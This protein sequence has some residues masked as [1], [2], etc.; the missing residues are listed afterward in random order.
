MAVNLLL[1]FIFSGI[2]GAGG[3]YKKALSKTGVLGALVVGTMIF[4]LGGWI[5]GVVLIAFFI[6][7]SGLSFFKAKSKSA[8]A[9]KFD[10]GHRR[11]FGQALANGGV[12][13][14]IALMG[15]LWPG[16]WW[17]FAFL[18]AMGT[19]NA[20]T[21]AT[22]LGVLA[23]APP[24]L[25]TNG[26]SVPPGTSGAISVFG[27][28]ASLTGALFIGGVAWVFTGIGANST[29]SAHAIPFI[30]I[31]GFA[32]LFG[33]LTDSLLG[34]TIQTIYHCDVCDKQTEQKYHRACGLT[35]TRQIRGLSWLNNDLVN[36]FS[37]IAGAIFA[38]CLA[39]LLK[40]IG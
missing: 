34:A 37:A 8:V 30:L 1:G 39:G 28:V 18:G 4:G 16:E 40:N 11:D 2:M 14:I 19:V 17:W 31:A 12:G 3:Y 9:E 21:W 23:K 32:G 35:P 6:S 5:W 24:R 33:S 29:A 38:V 13:A 22:E 25:I 10:K 36:F 20:D 15:Q 7:S 27:T 26:K